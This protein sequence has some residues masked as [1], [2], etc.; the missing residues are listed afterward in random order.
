MRRRELIAGLGSAAAWSLVAR[1]QQAD[2]VRR[3][4]VL[5]LFDENA[6]SKSVSSTA[7]RA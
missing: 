4:G 7:G 5:L 6:P 2:R 1:A 3:I